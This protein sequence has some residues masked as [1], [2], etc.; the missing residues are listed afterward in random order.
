M[1][2]LGELALVRGD[3]RSAASYYAE[4]LALRRALDDRRGIAWALHK[5]GQLALAEQAWQRAAEVFAEGLTLA[6]EVGD[7]ENIAWLLYHSGLLA[8]E[9]HDLAGAAAG[10]VESAR[11]LHVLGAGQ[12][13]ALN[14]VGLA[15]MMIQHQ[16]LIQAVRLLSVA[17]A[18]HWVAA[19]SWWI[20]GDQAIYDHTV[21]TVR[22][23]LDQATFA[24]AWAEARAITLEQALAAALDY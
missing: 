9:Q 16:D 17:E 20:A 11:L 24:T 14:L 13:V 12:G 1:L 4:S 6:R 19:G 15:T 23:R 5:L 2:G 7:Q 22:A 8:L 21:A 18:Q 10:F 3:R